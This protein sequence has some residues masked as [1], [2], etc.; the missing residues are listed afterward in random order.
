MNK[1]LKKYLVLGILFIFPIVVYLFFASGI[2]N[3][4]K[5]PILQKNIA[6]I[7]EWQTLSGKNVQLENYISIIGF[8]GNDLDYRKLDAFN[9]N[10]KIYKRFYKFKDL[11]FIMVVLSDNQDKLMEIIDELKKGS[12]EDM[13]KWK[14]I[15]G[16]E[17]KIQRLFSSFGSDIELNN[18]LSTPFVFIVDKDKNLRGRDDDNSM[19]TLYGYNSSSV[20]ELTKK[21]TDD[22]KVILAEY[23][24]ALKKNNKY[25][26][27]REI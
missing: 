22:I 13:S 3:F 20:A 15:L 16:D 17:T 4:A 19:G 10:Q 21:M 7:A 1:H 24:L 9:L 27:D 14:F 11:Q 8:W 2:N 5:L 26:L 25:K 12:S 18:K 23:R 6:E